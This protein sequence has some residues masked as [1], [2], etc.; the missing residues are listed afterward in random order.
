MKVIIASY[1]YTGKLHNKIIFWYTW[2][3]NPFTTGSSHIEIILPLM[4]KNMCFSSTNRDGAKGTR[5]ESI[6]KV[7]K[8]PERWDFYEKEYCESKV[9]KMVKRADSIL[10]CEYDWWGI[11]GFATLFG[12]LNDKEKWYC[13]E[14]CW[15]TLIGIWRRRISP[16]R[17]LSRIKKLGFTKISYNLLSIN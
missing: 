13:S 12:L 5:W 9:V 2:L 14:A 16:R 10:D 1:K 17:L 6:K 8:H 7:I 15:F 3:F 11:V 4:G